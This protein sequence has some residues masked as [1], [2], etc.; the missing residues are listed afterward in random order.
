[1]SLTV[2]QLIGRL[3]MMPDDAPVRSVAITRSGW[4]HDRD[5]VGVDAVDVDLGDDGG[6]AGVWLVGSRPAAIAPPVLLTVTCG[7]G[8]AV[9]VDEAAPWPADHLDCEH[10]GLSG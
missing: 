2:G 4:F 10:P 7:C 3:R 9:Q 1:M 6:V 8:Q 5:Q